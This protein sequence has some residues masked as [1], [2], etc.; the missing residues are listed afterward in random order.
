[1]T[2]AADGAREDILKRIEELGPWYHCITLGD[3]IETPGRGGNIRNKFAKFAK[4]VPDDL[5]GRRVLDVGCNAGG[6]TL[7]FARRGAA[8]KGVELQAHYL[9]QAAYC[10]E[11]AGLADRCEFVRED[12]YALINDQTQYDFILFMGLI[13]HLRYPQLALDLLCSRLRGRIF[14]NTPTV[15]PGDKPVAELRIPA[16]A[17]PHSLRR[18]PK[19]NLWFLSPAAIIRMMRLAGFSDIEVLW[20]SE[21]RFTSSASFE[22]NETH[23]ATGQALITGVRDP[24][25]RPTA[26]EELWSY[27]SGA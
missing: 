15:L 11:V 12:V 17:E 9:R 3:G 8:C 2:E 21:D 22:N 27:K 25:F 18:Y 5:E 4:Y 16:D 23:L 6:L 26:A 13:Y 20:T 7:E 24:S 14:L 19:F 10:A 1:M